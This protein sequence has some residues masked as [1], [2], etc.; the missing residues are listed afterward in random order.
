MK[1]R[2]S[3]APQRECHRDRN[4]SRASD[5]SNGTSQR[6]WEVKLLWNGGRS[7]IHG[8][9]WSEGVDA[10]NQEALKLWPALASTTPCGDGMQGLGC[11]DN[12][13]GSKTKPG[14][15]Y[16]GFATLRYGQASVMI[17]VESVT[18]SSVCRYGAQL[19]KQALLSRNL[20]KAG[21]SYIYIFSTRRLAVFTPRTAVNPTLAPLGS[22]DPA[23]SVPLESARGQA[24][25]L[26]IQAQARES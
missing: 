4:R 16:Q 24:S 13:D 20:S 2:E 25:R 5:L 11:Q 10:V 23:P 9:F 21:I 3:R 14:M 12:V 7:E 17:V 22:H 19:V 26:P 1:S 6:L 8:V 15:P 18:S